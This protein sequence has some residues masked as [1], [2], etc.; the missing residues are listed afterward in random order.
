ME[1]FNRQQRERMAGRRRNLEMK[2]KIWEGIEW[3][4][5]E[6]ERWKG[7]WVVCMAEGREYK[8]SVSNCK[9]EKGLLADMERNA[10]QRG[11]KFEKCYKCGILQS[12]SSRFESNGKGG[13]R[14]K[15]GE[16]YCQYLGTMDGEAC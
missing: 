10:A 7:I 9:S 1:E 16:Q 4:E 2:Q 13:F 6:L 15:E 8:H 11:I 12:I 3:L 14:K 5:R